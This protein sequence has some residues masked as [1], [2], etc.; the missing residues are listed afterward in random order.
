[1][2]S[3]TMFSSR[4][5]RRQPATSGAGHAVFKVDGSALTN[6][7][8]LSSRGAES[9][10]RKASARQA[11][12]SSPVR[13]ASDAARNSSAG[14]S[15]TEP[16]GPRASASCPTMCPSRK[17]TIGWNSMRMLPSR[18]N[19]S[20]PCRAAAVRSSVATLRC[21]TAHPAAGIPHWRGWQSPRARSLYL[22]ASNYGDT[23]RSRHFGR[24]DA[25][26]APVRE[27]VAQVRSCRVR[28]RAVPI[29]VGLPM[30][31]ATGFHGR[32]GGPVSRQQGQNRGPVRTAAA[33]V[34][35]AEKGRQVPGG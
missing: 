14:A 31:G 24:A 32:R 16:P 20:A 30:T 13:P 12:S 5:A 34:A 2:T 27:N 35:E 1:M 25:R 8:Q 7:R 23:E 21:I 28:L 15:S 18:A 10:Q 33:G 19:A 3:T 11:Q 9:A 29:A 17:S 22:T 6:S 4:C 26:A